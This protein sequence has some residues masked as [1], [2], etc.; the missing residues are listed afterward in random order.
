M[1]YRVRVGLGRAAELLGL[2]TQGQPL[3]ERLRLSLSCFCSLE[4]EEEKLKENQQEEILT[5]SNMINLMLMINSVLLCC[6][7]FFGVPATHLNFPLS[8]Q[9]KT[10]LIRVDG[11]S[12]PTTE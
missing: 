11:E 4:G 2:V 9:L 8:P 6:V 5:L 1:C 10:Y 7:L 3:S 12:R